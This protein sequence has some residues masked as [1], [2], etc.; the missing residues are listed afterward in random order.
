ML[1]PRMDAQTKW[2]SALVHWSIMIVASAAGLPFLMPRVE[3][4]SPLHE[5]FKEKPRLMSC[6]VV[7][8]LAAFS[9]IWMNKGGCDNTKRR[10]SPPAGRVTSEK[11]N[12]AHYFSS[13]L[14][15]MQDFWWQYVGFP[16]HFRAS[17]VFGLMKGF[18]QHS[19]SV[20]WESTRLMPHRLAWWIKNTGEDCPEGVSVDLTAAEKCQVAGAIPGQHDCLAAVLGDTGPCGRLVRKVIPD[21]FL[22]HFG[23]IFGD[24]ISTRALEITGRLWELGSQGFCGKADEAGWLAK[25]WLK[26]GTKSKPGITFTME[27]KYMRKGLFLYRT[28][29][30][31][32]NAQLEE[33][34]KFN[35]SLEERLKWDWTACDSRK[36]AD[37]DD[38]EA[39]E[40]TGFYFLESRMPGPMANREYVFAR[41]V[42]KRTDGGSY[43]VCVSAPHPDIGKP[44]GRNV[45]VDEFNTGFVMRPVRSR[46]GRSTPAVEI[47]SLYYDSPKMRS[48]AYN[49]AMKSGMW[50]AVQGLEEAFRKYKMRTDEPQQPKAREAAGQDGVVRRNQRR[51]RPF[52]R[53]VSLAK[54]AV[55]LGVIVAVANLTKGKSGMR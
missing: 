24:K 9:W 12:V 43:C 46:Q 47:A 6:A 55:K 50:T 36:L 10:S 48:M 38:A 27:K 25:P 29:T 4:S 52:S 42:W 20:A 39:D 34:S 45:R 13:A 14:A 22:L 5:V 18:A 40:N 23:A 11:N 7:A 33:F 51:R 16:L 26:C 19:F 15:Y 31:I 37:T 44:I 35:F 17:R 21:V 41:R 8:S 53:V 54:G 1:G 3:G 28:S 32:E 2:P 49:I 30:V